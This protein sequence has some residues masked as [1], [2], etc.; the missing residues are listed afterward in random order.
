MSKRV[1]RAIAHYRDGFPNDPPSSFYIQVIDDSNDPRYQMGDVLLVDPSLQP[2]QGDMVL[3]CH[4]ASD[5]LI[6]R[7]FQQTGKRRC[8]FAALNVGWGVERLTKSQARIVGVIGVRRRP[9]GEM[10]EKVR[11]EIRQREGL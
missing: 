3:L 1:R 8:D 10:A 2:E 4:Y 7:R 5:S 6:V 9:V 11:A